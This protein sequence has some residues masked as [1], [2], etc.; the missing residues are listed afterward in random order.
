MDV[1]YGDGD[2]QAGAGATVRLADV[3]AT[4]FVEQLDA[5]RRVGQADFGEHRI[6]HTPAALEHAE[7]IAWGNDG[8]TGQRIHARQRPARLLLGRQYGIG[9]CFDL[10]GRRPLIARKDARRAADAGRFALAGEGFAHDV[11]FEREDAVVI[12]CPAPQHCARRHDRP[13][14]IFDDVEM[15][16][17]ARLARDAI[18]GGVD[19]A[20]ELGGLAVEQA[21]AALRVGRRRPAPALRIAR[22]YMRALQRRHIVGMAIAFGWLAAHTGIAAMAIDAGQ[23]DGW[24]GVHRAFVARRMATGA[25]TIRIVAEG[26]PFVDAADR[27]LTWRDGCCAI[28]AGDGTFALCGVHCGHCDGE[29]RKHRKQRDQQSSASRREQGAELVGYA[30]H[31]HYRSEGESGVGEDRIIGIVAGRIGA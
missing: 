8:P 18:V 26:R 9:R 30:V 31:G 2:A 22:Q 4:G 17:P 5:P 13:F 3:G 25:A 27:L 15:A 10:A 7:H 16:R 28:G 24:R 19:E 20:D 23:L 11:I 1:E 21:I 12:A 29:R 14:G 6:D